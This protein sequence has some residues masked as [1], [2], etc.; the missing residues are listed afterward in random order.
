MPEVRTSLKFL[1]NNRKGFSIAVSDTDS[2]FLNDRHLAFLTKLL[3]ACKLNLGDIALVNL[4]GEKASRI[5]QIKKELKPSRM[6]L[7]GLSPLS[8][9]LPLDFP[10]F[11]I[12]EYDGCEYLSGPAL[13][14]MDQDSR[15]G[16]LLKTK[17]W[18]SLKQLLTIP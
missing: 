4:V 9:G 3:E 14:E 17:L 11:K 15:E 5:D 7:F 1:G 12:Q 2:V 10:Q 6:L 18:M 8:I 16:K 13:G